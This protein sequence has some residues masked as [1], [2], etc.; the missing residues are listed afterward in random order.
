[1]KLLVQFS[2]TITARSNLETR[3]K[4]RPP[5][6]NGLGICNLPF[7]FQTLDKLNDSNIGAIY[8]HHMLAVCNKCV[9]FK[10]VITRRS[11]GIACCMSIW[12]NRRQ[13]FCSH[14]IVGR[15]SVAVYLDI[16]ANETEHRAL[17]RLMCASALQ[18]RQRFRIG[19]RPAAVAVWRS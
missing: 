17:E 10:M 2:R 8:S 16:A 1:M 6:L 15:H 11:Y 5:R 12:H 13:S 7:R 9:Q 3:E 4:L 18:E 19:V 14:C